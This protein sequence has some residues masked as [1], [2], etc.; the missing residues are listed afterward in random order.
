M[1]LNERGCHDTVFLGVEGGE[2]QEQTKGERV[3]VRSYYPTLV[4]VCNIQC[5]TC[6]R[7]ARSF[8]VFTLGDPDH[9][10]PFKTKQST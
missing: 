4:L 7:T 3:D 6:L 9:P 2:W 5:R 10:V 8:P 1:A